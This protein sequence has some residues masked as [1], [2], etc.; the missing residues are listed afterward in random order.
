M[1]T[2]PPILGETGVGEEMLHYVT[3]IIDNYSEWM[4][5]LGDLVNKTKSLKLELTIFM[6]H[7]I[8]L[9]ANFTEHG[10]VLFGNV[11]FFS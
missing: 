5:S 6:S 8:K 2:I 3:R 1:F 9:E 7:V 11:S 10:G 4:G